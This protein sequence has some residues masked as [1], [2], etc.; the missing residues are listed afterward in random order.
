[1]PWDNKAGSSKRMYFY[2]HNNTTLTIICL[3]I[4]SHIKVAKYFA[5]FEESS[6]A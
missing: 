3:A 2:A 6:H 5:Y 4:R 1:M